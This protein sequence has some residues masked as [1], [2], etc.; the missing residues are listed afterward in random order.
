MQFEIQLYKGIPEVFHSGSNYD[1]HFIKKMLAKMFKEE[2]NC[3]RENTEKYQIF[4][5]PVTKEVKRIHQN[6]KEI[7]KA[8]LW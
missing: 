6:N 8:K 1:Y 3:L 5:V 4:S 2:F 7:P